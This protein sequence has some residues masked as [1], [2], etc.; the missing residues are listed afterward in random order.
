MDGNKET[1]L[2]VWH[3]H[4]EQDCTLTGHAD[5]DGNKETQLTVWHS[6]QGTRLYTDRTHRHGW[7]QRN[8]T[9]SL[10]LTSRNKTVHCDRTHRH[11]WKQRNTTNSLALTSRNKTVH[12]QDTQTDMD[13]NKETQLTVW[14]SH[15]GTRLYTDRTHRQEQDTT[16]STLKEQDRTLS[17]HTDMDGNKETQLTVWH[18]HQGTRLYTD[19]TRRHGWKQRNTT[20]SLA[21]TSRNKTV[22]CQDTQTWMETKK[23]N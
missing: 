1:Q 12:C 13:G 5:M 8:T 15:Q 17:G 10:A 6:H 2:T 11:G 3:S 14:H 16:N 23:H 20:N 22:H 9:N 18:S 21:L 7:K 19:R 4:R